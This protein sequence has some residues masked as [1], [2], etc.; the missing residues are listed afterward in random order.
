MRQQRVVLIG[1]ADFLSNANIGVLGNG[2][3]G[4]NVVNWLAARKAALSIAI[5]KAPDHNLYLPGWASWLITAGFIVVLPLLLI[6][7]G[8]IR[9]TLRRRR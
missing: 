2:A 4:V 7:F 6:A 9:W 1:D 5:P 8:I 3:L